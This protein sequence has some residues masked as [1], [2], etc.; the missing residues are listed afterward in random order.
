MIWGVL[1]AVGVIAFLVFFFRGH[2]LWLLIWALGLVAVIASALL[3]QALMDSDGYGSVIGPVVATASRVGWVV[4]IFAAIVLV[5]DIAAIAIYIVLRGQSDNLKGKV[6]TE[7]RPLSAM[8]LRIPSP[9]GWSKRKVL[10]SK[11][12][13][14]SMESLVDGTATLGER[15]MVA[16]FFAAAI[17]F[18]SIFVGAGL[19]MM[20]NLWIFGLFPVIPGIWLYRILRETSQDY[21]EAKKRVARRRGE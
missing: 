21:R 9:M 8:S 19:M 18:F 10:G 11:S 12:E 1:W 6:I 14:V 5:A 17:A 2:L 4:L 15:M 16:G 13:F 20:Q 3:Q 7:N